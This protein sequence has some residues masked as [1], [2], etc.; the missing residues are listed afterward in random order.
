MSVEQL[1]A[2]LARRRGIYTALNEIEFPDLEDD[3]GF[4]E[5]MLREKREFDYFEN[6]Q[7]SLDESE[8]E[9]MVGLFPNHDILKNDETTRKKL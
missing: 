8:N 7:G 9:N 2:R 6:M 3:F 5:Q 4:V 1:E